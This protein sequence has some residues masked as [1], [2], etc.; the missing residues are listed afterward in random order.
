ME[1]FI[2]EEEPTV[3]EL[4]RAIRKA[5]LDGSGVPVL[6][7]SAF[8]NKGVQLVLDA[9]VD[10]LPSPRRRARRHRP[11]AVQGGRARRARARRRRAVLRPR[12][13]DHVRPLRRAADVPARVLG[14]AQERLARAQL[15]EGPQGAHRAHPADA[16]E[17]PRG[18]GRRL[19]GRHRRGG[20]AQ[21]LHHRRHDL[22]PRRAGR[23]GADQLPD[24]R[25][26]GRGRAEDQ[27]RP[28]QARRRASAKL[29]DEDPTFV[30]RFDDETGQ[31]VISG[32]G[33]LHLDIIVDRLRREFNVDANVGKPQV[34][35]RETIR[36]PV[37]KVDLHVRRA[38]PA[39][40]AS[41]ATSCSTSSRRAPA[42]ATSSS[43]RSSGGKI[44]REYIPS[45][46]Q[47][48]QEA[49]GQRR[50]G[51]LP[52]GRRPR[53]A[54]R[55]LLPRGR[56]LRDGVQDRRVDGAKE[57]A[58]KAD[59]VLLEPVMEFEVTT[60]EEF[61]GDVMGDVTARRGRIENIDERGGPEDRPGRWCRWPSCS[62]TRPTCGRETQGRAAH[63]PMQLHA[64]NEVPAQIAQGDRR[65]GHGRVDRGT[66]R[67]RQMAQ[68]EVRAHQAPREHRHD[69]AHRPRQDHAHRGDHQAPGRQGP[70]RLHPVRPDR[71]GPGGARARHH[72]RDRP[73]R[74][75]DRQPPLRPRGLPG[76]RRLRQEHDHRRRPDGRR[77]PGGLGRR[78]PHAPDPRARAAG[79]PG[80]RALHRRVAE[81]VRH[82]RRPRAA[83]P[84][85]ARGPRAAHLLR[86]P[87]RRRPGHPGVGAEGARGR[88]GLGRED[89]RAHGA[90]ATPT[91][92]S[93]CATSTSPS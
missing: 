10:Y 29:A 2:D 82:G 60:P 86:V 57:G 14:R 30:V 75:P 24:A 67:E 52:D 23:A 5:T 22:R 35:Y 62:A 71:Q 68:A 26:R 66:R 72:D 58:R 92:P 4:K 46:D 43:T 85:R 81:Q 8:K 25:D 64:Y 78:R 32:M 73:R 50:P 20:R 16:R 6:C 17:P 21:A 45:V 87:R 91:S 15:D 53:H 44:P 36:K 51:R 83:R 19:H 76:P 41:T 11:H 12:V 27:G 28:G 55:R 93:P 70:R 3:E 13:Q 34:A 9:I 89:R 77:D 48:I 39:A 56:L 40:A 63:S 49:H 54:D 7:G 31:T 65:P 90:R 80:R 42:A 1:K 74:V 84:R 69:R 59:P 37:H 61:L 88:R 47:G 79:P 38:R 33:E 18:H